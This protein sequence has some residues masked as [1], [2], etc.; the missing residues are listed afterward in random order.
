[1]IDVVD[2]ERGRRWRAFFIIAFFSPHLLLCIDI[3]IANHA[4]HFCKREYIALFNQRRI[5][6]IKDE[7]GELRCIVAANSTN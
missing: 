6:G 2:D 4:R 7:S 5:V 1:M 3:D